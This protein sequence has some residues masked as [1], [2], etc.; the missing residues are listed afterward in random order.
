MQWCI[1]FAPWKSTSPLDPANYWASG[2]EQQEV[3]GNDIK[4]KG[5][6]TEHFGN[7]DL[8]YFVWEYNIGVF[9]KRN[10]R[11]RQIRIPT[12]RLFWV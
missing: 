6:G 11:A 8:A 4:V 3:V 1:L 10:L 9:R 2:V 12:D 7:G 5:Y